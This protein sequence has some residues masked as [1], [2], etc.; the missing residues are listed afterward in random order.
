MI[1]IC[2]KLRMPTEVHEHS[3]L[4]YVLYQKRYKWL[5]LATLAHSGHCRGTKNGSE[6]IDEKSQ[7]QEVSTEALIIAVLM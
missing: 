2:E 1:G 7:I 5:T 6:D 4:N 3:S